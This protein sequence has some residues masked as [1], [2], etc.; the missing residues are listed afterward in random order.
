MK[1]SDVADSVFL[2]VVEDVRRHDRRWTLC[3]DLEAALPGIPPKVLRA[4][5]RALIR[6][7]LLT[8]CTCGC[9]GDYELTAKGDRFLAEAPTPTEETE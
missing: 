7:G 1:A 3:W 9:R 6:R 4:K 8:G 2:G 5:A